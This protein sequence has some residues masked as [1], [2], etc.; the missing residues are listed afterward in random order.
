MNCTRRS[1]QVRKNRWSRHIPGRALR[2]TTLHRIP[3]PSA[4]AAASIESTCGSCR[5]AERCLPGH[6]CRN[7]PTSAVYYSAKKRFLGFQF[8]ETRAVAGRDFPCDF[9]YCPVYLSDPLRTARQRY[10]S[11]SD[12]SRHMFLIDRKQPDIIGRTLRIREE[13]V[14][15]WWL[16]DDVDVETECRPTRQQLDKLGL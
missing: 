10:P 2:L 5:R 16:T 9:F 3:P 7:T 12:F 1:R 13:K 6:N 11:V 4:A 15:S 14:T 8:C